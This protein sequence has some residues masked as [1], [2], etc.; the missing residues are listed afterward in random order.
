MSG[1]QG[2]IALWH[3]Q[4]SR[5]GG[6][7][8][9]TEPVD[10][11]A[12]DGWTGDDHSAALACYRK[13]ASLPGELPPAPPQDNLTDLF[14]DRGR[15][16]AFFEETFSAHRILAEPGLL[17]S[18]FEPVLKGSRRRSTEYSVPVYRRPRNLKPLPL[19][20]PLL[21][22]GL[23]AGREVSGQF[24][25][26]PTRAGIEAGALDGQDLELLYL[27]DPIDAFIMHVQGSG[28]VELD[29][30]TAVRLSFDGKN[31]H[32]YTSISKH[33]VKQGLIALEDAHLDG[34]IAR[35]RAHPMPQLFLN[36][37]QSYIFFREL[38]SSEPGPKGSSGAVLLAARSLAAD[39]LY[40]GF[41]SPLWVAAP[42]LTFE[43]KPLR[44]LL[45]AQDTGS[46][47]RGPQRGDIFAGSGVEAGRIAGRI[48]HACEFV[49][50]RPRH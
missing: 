40:H 50:L 34:L 12:L 26:Y 36:E 21:G 43:G 28:L 6:R 18:Y 1:G 7:P 20:H 8:L 31:G 44:R 29:D 14:Q 46:A 41:G 25:P 37:N 15:A 5:A 22:L 42:E 45:I 49:I 35:L 48:R 11:S 38:E 32:P 19:G 39:P 33:L 16:R 2:Q 30:G 10:F 9:S 24:E 27:A 4:H 17:T 13:S 3:W 23:T 47:I